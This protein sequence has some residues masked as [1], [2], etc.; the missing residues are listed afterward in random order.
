[1][2]NITG[3]QKDY[4]R[5][6][7]ELNKY[8][9]VFALLILTETSYGEKEKLSEYKLDP[10]YK[11]EDYNERMNIYFKHMLSTFFKV[12]NAGDVYNTYRELF[13]VSYL[14]NTNDDT[15]DYKDE[16]MLKLNKIYTFISSNSDKE[17]RG[18]ELLRAIRKEVNGV[19]EE[20]NDSYYD[21]S[22][23]ELKQQSDMIRN[24]SDLDTKMSY[25]PSFLTNLADMESHLFKAKLFYDDYRKSVT[26]LM[27]YLLLKARLPLI[28]IK[29]IELDNYYEY[30]NLANESF[31][32]S[33]IETFYKEKMCDSIESDLI[34][35][36]KNSMAHYIDVNNKQESGLLENK[37]L[38]FKQNK[39]K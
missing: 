2:A 17:Y 32:N 36:M 38:T 21:A 19:D 3:Y 6:Y 4:V 9:N 8:T 37:I 18:S 24:E 12:D 31:D 33:E 5:A 13:K 25:I 28:Y 23:N 11:A 35:P 15:N 29:P 10:K 34:V 27:N 22:F 1:M 26:G 30:I 16:T 39:Y 7:E 14:D 20:I